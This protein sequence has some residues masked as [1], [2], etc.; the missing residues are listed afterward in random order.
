MT[1]VLVVASYA[2]SLLAFRG[3][4]I[5]ALLARG[6]DVHCAAPELKGQVESILVAMGCHCHDVPMA[7]AGIAPAGDI[8][9]FRR[10]LRI[11]RE[12]T[13]DCVL[14]YTVKPNVFAMAAARRAGVPVRV[15]LVTGLGFSFEQASDLRGRFLR[16]VARRLYRLGL[17][18][19]TRVVFQNPDDRALVERMFAIDA[20]KTTQVDGSGVNLAWFDERPLRTG[21]IVFL[22]IARL[23][24]AKG[25]VEYAEAAAVMRSKHPHVTF[26]L[27]GW[28]DAS[29]GA[30]DA[31]TLAGWQSSGAIEFLG[32]LDDVR[33]AI[34][35]CTVYVLP[36]YREGTPRT[37]LEAMAMGRAVITTDAPGCRETVVDG[38]NGFLVPVQS[39]DILVA[40]M[41]RFVADPALAQRMGQRS[42]QLAEDKYDVHKI[43]QRMLL[44]MGIPA[45]EP[46][47]PVTASST[48]LAEATS[49]GPRQ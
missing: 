19:A 36:S 8:A 5:R 41:E 21:P 35:R 28:I 42:R 44:E 9:L 23:L 24:K 17:S 7:R 26:L 47:S 12:Q 46:T 25:V 20:G 3:D 11:M 39:V 43:N 37:V 27:A 18:C 2:N 32:K 13:F 45:G 31:A 14:S 6:V 34:E 22:A 15:A 10:L 48:P 40:A 38:D 29:P 49:R 1:R 33:P 16:A 4:L 30:I